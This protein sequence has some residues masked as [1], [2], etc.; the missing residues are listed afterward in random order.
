MGADDLLGE[1]GE[2]LKPREV[3]SILKLTTDGEVGATVITE[4]DQIM[5]TEGREGTHHRIY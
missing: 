1:D 5:H 2:R 3:D 4:E